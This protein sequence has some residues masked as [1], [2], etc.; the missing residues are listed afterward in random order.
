[1]TLQ[2]S[3]DGTE[4]ARIA[5]T[6]PIQFTG[7][8]PAPEQI[9]SVTGTNVPIRNDAFM[10]STSN[11]KIVSGHGTTNGESISG[12]FLAGGTVPGT[13]TSSSNLVNEIRCSGNNTWI[14]GLK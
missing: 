10:F 12:Q 7:D 2:I 9:P 8:C 6:L 1:V 3:A 14:A 5:F 13:V 11:G 4:V